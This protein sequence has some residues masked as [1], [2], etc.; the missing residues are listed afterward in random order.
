MNEMDQWSS[1]AYQKPLPPIKRRMPGRP[2]HKRKRDAMK[3]DKN[4]IRISRKGQINHC[5]LCKKTR[6]NQKAC[7]SKPEGN[8]S[9]REVT[10]TGE[11]ISASVG[12]MTTSGEIVYAS[13]GNVSA[14]GEITSVRGGNVS[15]R[16]GKVLQEVTARG[17]NVFARGE[18][19]CARG[20]NVSARG[21]KVSAT[22]S[23]SPCRPPPG[24]E[25]SI[26]DT[27]SSAVRSTGGAIKL[28]EGV[29]SSKGRGD[30]SKSRMYPNGIRP[31]GFGV[32]WDP[33]DGI[34]P[35]DCIIHAATQSEIALSHSQLV[36]SQE[37]E[38]RQEEPRHQQ[39][40]QQ[41]KPRQQQQRN[42]EP[43]QQP[44]RT[45]ER[46]AQIMFY[47]PP[48]PGPGLDPDDAISLE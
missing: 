11:I 14:S 30:G 28:R 41:Q 6:H 48:T 4:R 27:A 45:S 40:R 19:V 21:G 12:V 44:R 36:E 47:K 34:T 29:V 46:I 7:P 3:D 15:A 42:Q 26:P 18:K 2:P 23:I 24:F 43:R 9:V 22:P 10:G 35:Q 32:S 13:G 17:G 31:I 37:E 39:P 5:T 1:T 38:P 25:M 16:G 20:G 8:A 33:I